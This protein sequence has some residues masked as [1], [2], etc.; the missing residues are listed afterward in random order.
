M[1]QT[2]VEEGQVDSVDGVSWKMMLSVD[3]LQVASP[4][5][6]AN[7]YERVWHFILELID[8]KQKISAMIPPT[9]FRTSVVF[10]LTGKGGNYGQVQVYARSKHHC[11]PD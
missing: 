6:M 9:C 3:D 10:K 4:H 2:W 7:A 8:Q 11:G 1:Q 5:T